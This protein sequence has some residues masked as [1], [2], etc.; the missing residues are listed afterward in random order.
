[1]SEIIQKIK[2]WYQNFSSSKISFERKGI[3]PTRDWNIVIF[4]SLVVLFICGGLAF[5]F[6]IKVDNGTFFGAT[7]SEELAEIK[8]NN[9]VLDKL[10]ADINA[11]EKNLIDIE[12]NRQA[13]PNPSI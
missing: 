3:K 8:I 10:I 11:R 6:Y 13:P 2:N 1:M 5:Y 7:V 12:T 9:K 4:S